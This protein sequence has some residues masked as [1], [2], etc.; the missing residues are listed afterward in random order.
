M[1]IHGENDIYKIDG[2]R[3]LL[4]ENL[5]FEA[6]VKSIITQH[7]RWLIINHDGKYDLYLPAYGKLCCIFNNVVEYQYEYGLLFVNQDSLYW[8]MISTY[9]FAIGLTEENLESKKSKLPKIFISKKGELQ[10]IN[11]ENG[12]AFFNVEDKGY[13]L[14]GNETEELCIKE[15][16]RFEILP[17]A[18]LFK[19]IKTSTEC[20]VNI[21]GDT[22]FG[23][24]AKIEEFANYEYPMLDGYY[25]YWGKDQF[26]NICGL[27]IGSDK[28]HGG[29]DY[30]ITFKLPVQKVVFCNRYILNKE[31]TSAIDV[32]KITID[33]KEHFIFQTIG[34]LDSKAIQLEIPKEDLFNC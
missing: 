20:F 17:I 27:H 26:N 6:D 9:D 32:W 33:E 25:G 34:K 11:V 5:V 18:Y 1:F 23:E 29:C 8:T 3:V 12:G 21:L 7:G 31:C 22:M 30:S 4:E 14:Y 13:I 15:V 24:F 10:I 16:G 28:E 19:L 2:R